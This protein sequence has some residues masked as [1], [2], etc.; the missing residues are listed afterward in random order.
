VHLFDDGPARDRLI[1]QDRL[2]SLTKPGYRRGKASSVDIDRLEAGL[3]VLL[4]YWK[5]DIRPIHPD[6]PP[7]RQSWPETEMWPEIRDRSVQW[8]QLHLDDRVVPVQGD[9]DPATYWD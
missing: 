1:E 8:F 9:V 4:P 3:P 7:G 6:E 5:I 2:L